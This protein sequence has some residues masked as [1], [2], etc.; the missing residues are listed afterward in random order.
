[1]SHTTIHWFHRDL[2][3]HD[4][5]A[6]SNGAHK[7][8]V[9]PIYILDEIHPPQEQRFGGASRWWLHHSLDKLNRSLDNK[10]SLYIGDPLLILPEI[11]RRLGVTDVNWN[12]GF[13]PWRKTLE[14]QVKAKLEKDGVRVEI[15]NGS[16]LWDPHEI[17]DPEGV[18]YTVFTRYYRKGCLK[19]TPPRKPLPKPGRLDLLKDPQAVSLDQ[20]RLLPKTGWDQKLIPQWAIGEEAAATR[21]Q[22]FIENGL[23]G[24][25]TGRNFLN[26]PHVS[27]L[28]PHL[29]HGE[30]SPNQV[31]YAAAAGIRRGKDLDHFHSELGWREFSYGLL[32]HFPTMTEQNLYPAFNQIPWSDDQTLLTAWQQGKTGYPIVDAA[33]RCL[34]Q[35]GYLHNRLR[36]TVG[37]F[38]TKNLLVHWRHGAAWFWDTL[39]DADLANNTASWQWVAGSG[40]DASSTFR[41]FNPVLQGKKWDQG[42]QFTRHFLPELADLPDR[43][44]WSPWE[45]PSD[46]LRRAGIVLGE[47]YP[48]PIVDLNRSKERAE[49]A[50]NAL[51]SRVN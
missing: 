16:L 49:A 11:I 18:P 34:W 29:S 13:E 40:A 35:S 32:T 1:M 21:L 4:N 23:D 3:L 12:S 22:A 38:L 31:W 10:L 14:A 9:V 45:A 6:L 28:S 48:S 42:G 44:L 19:S 46:L 8:A 33:M 43:Y 15:C 25:K 5:P 20:L 39:V 24:Y 7:G 50:F 37:S 51:H 36:L 30:I 26:G 17:S 47:T 41:L 2:R 27:R